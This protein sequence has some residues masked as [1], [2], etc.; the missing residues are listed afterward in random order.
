MEFTDEEKIW[1]QRISEE[2]PEG[3]ELTP[4]E[5]QIR[6]KAKPDT[7]FQGQLFQVMASIRFGLNDSTISTKGMK[8]SLQ[9]R[10]SVIC[11]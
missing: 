4:V 5:K 8:N 10:I 1:L 2:I 3:S 6:E 9:Q 11:G 7:E